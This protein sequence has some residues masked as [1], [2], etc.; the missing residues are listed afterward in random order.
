MIK[1]GERKKGRGKEGEKERE[2]EFEGVRKGEG[3]KNFKNV[4]LLK[5]RVISIKM[6][7]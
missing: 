6:I 1:K 3:K 4:N 5:M 2:G 7:T